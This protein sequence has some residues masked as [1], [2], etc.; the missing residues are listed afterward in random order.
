MKFLPKLLV[1]IFAL[2]VLIVFGLSLLD[3]FS[4][5]DQSSNPEDEPGPHPTNW[6]YS[7]RAYPFEE[8][9]PGKL[10]KAVQEAKVLRDI[11]LKSE[12]KNPVWEEAGPANIPGRITD[13]AVTSEGENYITY[14]A[15]AAGGV[16]KSVSS[17]G[18]SNWVPVFDDEGTQS[19][20]AIAIDP[21]DNNTVYVGT[22]ESNGNG[23]SYEGTGIY[24]SIDGGASWIH[25]GLDSTYHIGRV[26]VHPDNPD[27]I[28]V[29]GR[30]KLFGGGASSQ[31]GLHRSL[32]GGDSWS[33]VLHV[34]DYTACLD[35]AIHPSTGTVLTTMGT[36]HDNTRI[37]RSTDLGDSWTQLTG[38][39][40]LPES[41]DEPSRI[42]VTMDPLSNTAY[43]VWWASGETW[44]FKSTDLGLNWTQ[45]N[46]AAIHNVGSSFGWYFGQIR[47]IPG[48]PDYVFV[49]G[50]QLYLS[51]NGGQSWVDR[52][53][54]LHVD[55]HAMVALPDGN[56][57]DGS[58]GGVGHSSNFGVNWSIADSL[59]NTQ[60]Y[61]I[62]IDPQNSNSL[63]GGAQDNGT[64]RTSTG[65]VDDWDHIFGGDGF[66][67]NIDPR[68]SDVLYVEYQFGNL[69]K[70]YNGGG[71]WQWAMDGIDPEEYKGWNTPVVI[72]LL[73]PDVLYYGGTCLYKTTNGALKWNPISDPLTSSGYITTI[74]VA[75]SNPQVIYAGTSTSEVW[76]TTDGGTNWSLNTSGLPDRW[77]TRVTIDPYDAS[78]VYVCISGY[79]WG[80]PM[81]HVFRSI[82]YGQNWADISSN[83]PDAPVNDLIVDPHIDNRLYV[84]TDVGVYQTDNL[85]GSWTY[86]SMGAPIAVVS[87]LAFHASDRVL[88]AGTH[89]RSMFKAVMDCPDVLDD[90]LDGIGNDCDNCP[91]I[92]NSDQIDSDQD[93]V[94]NACDQCAGSNDFIDSDGDT[95]P[96]DCDLCPG[97]DDNA[98]SDSDGIADSCDN[99][100]D[101][102]NPGQEDSDGDNI[103]DACESC[104]VGE[105]V[106]NMDSDPTP[107]VDMGDLTLLIDMLF[108]NL[109]PVECLV[110]ADI[111][112]SGQ[113]DPIVTDVDMGDLTILIDHLFLSLTPLP[114]CP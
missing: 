10:I 83:L 93:F 106:G 103:G 97:Y 114:A 34:D 16:F 20:G 61:A 78:I 39:N 52:G 60:F 18:I 88:V 23:D 29:A 71:S 37:H 76:V 64:M 100:P 109:T 58:D 53:S 38:A 8:I 17:Q 98:D 86:I 26:V 62:N 48:M 31:R 70:S 47:V 110:E 59:P 33:L 24:K 36:S 14:A 104:C 99:C 91:Q 35:V 40:G 90:D 15:S 11:A 27:I 111:D 105:S 1:S 94:G 12:T 19:I 85:G 30:G 67:V 9:P 21:T 49:H 82:D 75:R 55:H 4:N 65:A 63:Y 112:F 72:D 69:Y 5:S 2:L 73:N 51:T 108:I 107:P 28:F 42:G 89:G 66:Y 44:V 3:K 32:D 7:Q 101:H 46:D 113:P 25:K 54:G 79:R 84:G 87:D 45:T 102:Y 41:G 74:D 22:G 56:V 95:V 68:D 80:E 57:W 43:S 13:I 81:S 92:A 50:V 77:I 96:D 6:F